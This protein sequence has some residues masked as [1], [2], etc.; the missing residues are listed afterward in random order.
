MDTVFFLSI[1]PT[2]PLNTVTSE[3]LIVFVNYWPDVFKGHTVNEA[4]GVVD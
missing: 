1:Q 3:H 2:P 4:M